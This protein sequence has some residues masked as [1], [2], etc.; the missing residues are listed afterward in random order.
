MLMLKRAEVLVLVL[1][2]TTVFS[3]SALGKVLFEDDFEAE[4][5][6]GEPSL[7]N[8]V[9]DFT[10]QVVEDPQ[11]PSNKILA[12]E[13][14]GNGLGV[15]TP[16]GSEDQGWTDYIWEF[17]WMWDQDTYQGTAHR[18]QGAE[19][20][21]HASR[22]EGGENLIIYMWD[23]DFGELQAGPWQSG[24]EVWYRMQISA[25]GNQHIVKGKERDDGTPFEEIDPIVSVE[26]DT[27]AD[28]TIGLF[29]GAGLYWDN[30]IVYEPGTVITAVNPAAKLAATWG[31]LKVGY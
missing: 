21:Y 28:G 12:Q 31:K 26:D 5:L 18:Y 7:W 9:P 3:L 25:I 14:E 19:G 29:G 8:I 16:V 2:L 17:D 10:L 1:S 22:R 20:Y 24:N 11:D 27:Y 4:T 23:G 13:G 15:P 30:M 6:N